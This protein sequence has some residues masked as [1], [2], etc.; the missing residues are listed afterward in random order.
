[1]NLFTMTEFVVWYKFQET[2][3][4]EDEHNRLSVICKSFGEKYGYHT[5]SYG[6]FG[7]EAYMAHIIVDGLTK[8]PQSSGGVKEGAEALE[9]LDG[10][11]VYHTQ[12]ESIM[13]EFASYLKVPY[14]NVDMQFA[15]KTCVD[16][17]VK[18]M[19]SQSATRAVVGDTGY[20]IVL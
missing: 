10:Q 4:S 20:I 7:D 17:F 8:S 15:E 12:L 13:T 3:L 14:D 11:L 6:R 5:V 16:G 9:Y 19:R 2:D 1:M 18:Q